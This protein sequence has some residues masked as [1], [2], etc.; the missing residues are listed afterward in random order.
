MSEEIKSTKLRSGQEKK[1][2]K[3]D[4]HNLII[5][6]LFVTVIW[7]MFILSMPFDLLI[8]DEEAP[9]SG[10]YAGITYM[11][12]PMVFTIMYY[13]STLPAFIGILIFTGVTKRNKFIFRSFL[14][15]HA[16]NSAG[17]LLLGFLFGFLTNFSCIAAALIH[18]DIKL[19]FSFTASQI[20]FFLFAFLCVF[21]QSSSEEMWCRGFVYERVNVRYPLWVAILVNSLFFAALHIANPGATVLSIVSIAVCG[22]SYSIAKWYTGSIWFPMGLHTAWNFTQNFAFGLPNSGLV[23]AESIFSL[24]SANARSNLIYDPAF[25]V[26]GAVPAI[27]ADAAIAAVCLALAA[28]EGRLKELRGRRDRRETV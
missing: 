27:L 13:L 16:G 3:I 20:P 10:W 26:E 23:S 19:Y 4:Y 12:D 24:E 9:L 21:I 14:P 15:G 1:K 2:K 8:F 17:K 5:W 28:K 7:Y 11:H 25:G 18:G 6:I 22:L